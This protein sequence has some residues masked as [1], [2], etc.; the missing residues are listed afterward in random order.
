MIGL[1]QYGVSYEC[2]DSRDQSAACYD[3]IRKVTPNGSFV[4]GE[5]TLPCLT[6]AC[7]T[8][9]CPTEPYLALPSK[10]YQRINGLSMH[11]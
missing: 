11:P 2:L 4:K 9:P 3:H 6:V 7:R 1:L 10:G 5:G 8:R